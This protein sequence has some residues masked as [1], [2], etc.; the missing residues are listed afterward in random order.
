M[1]SYY[2]NCECTLVSSDACIGCTNIEI[3]LFY[4]SAQTRRSSCS[5]AT[6]VVDRA[7]ITVK[8]LEDRFNLKYGY[9]W[10]FLNEQPFSEDFKRWASPP[11]SVGLTEKWVIAVC[12]SLPR[13]RCTLAKS[14]RIIG[15]SQTGSMRPGPGRK[16]QDGGRGC[17]IRRQCLVRLRP[18]LIPS[19]GLTCIYSGTAI[20]AVSTLGYFSL[21]MFVPLPSSTDTSPASSSTAS[22]YS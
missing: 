6:D 9:P 8:E 4:D 3:G 5:R 15:T 14:R 17:Y 21:L 16:A 1:V 22:H 18:P 12:R 19:V 10:V 11:L 7:V 20:C 13:A 2:S